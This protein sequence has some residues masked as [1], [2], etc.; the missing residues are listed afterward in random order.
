MPFDHRPWDIGTGVRGY[1]W[2]ARSPRAVLLLQHGF[3]EYAQRYV[4]RYHRLIPRLLDIGITVY[5]FDLNGHG[6]SPGDRGMTDVDEA[7]SHH[8]VARRTLATQPLPIFLLGHS[9]GG[10]FTAASVV[11][12]AANLRGVVLTSAP[13]LVTANPLERFFL[14][15]TAAIVPARI[16]KRFDIN[17]ISRIREEVQAAIDDPMIYKEGMAAR[18]AASVLFT[19]RDNWPRY[20][21]WHV[22]TLALHGTVD[23]FTEVEGTRRFI[24][25]IGSS[26]KTLHIVDGGYHELLNDIGAEDTLRLILTW[27]ERRLQ[28]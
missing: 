23:S 19:G 9:L 17:G 6:H 4:E 13:L 11:R 3:G 28:S 26:D 20:A 8:L 25:T 22:P 5:A 27:L 2:D 24:P 7:V 16:V 10:I 1:A 12:D 14:R 21:Q 18:L 15:V